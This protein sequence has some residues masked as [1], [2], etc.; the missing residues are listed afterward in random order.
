VE[1]HR[2]TQ[3]K[4]WRKRIKKFWKP[5]MLINFIKTNPISIH[6]LFKARFSLHKLA[7]II[8]KFLTSTLPH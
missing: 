2:K 6:F 3:A 4:M 7:L 8:E 1:K 5:N